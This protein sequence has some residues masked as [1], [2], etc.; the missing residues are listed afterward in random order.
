MKVMRLRKP[1]GLENLYLDDIAPREPGTGEIRVRVH[2]TSLNYH[3]MPSSRARSRRPKVA[4][5]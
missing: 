4:Y 1:G 5:R 3:D 2:A